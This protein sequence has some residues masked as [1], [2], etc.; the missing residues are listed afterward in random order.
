MV[1]SSGKQEADSDFFAE[2]DA[3]YQIDSDQDNE[4]SDTDTRRMGKKAVET[5][6]FLSNNL[7]NDVRQMLEDNGLKYKQQNQ[8]QAEV[9]VLYFLLLVG[10]STNRKEK[11]SWSLKTQPFSKNINTIETFSI[12]N[13]DFFVPL[14][15][16]P[17]LK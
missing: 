11:N 2:D 5:R 16:S 7:D 8:N 6:A 3:R 14:Y 17:F 9:S 12:K 15:C 10:V 4:E 13:K 1:E